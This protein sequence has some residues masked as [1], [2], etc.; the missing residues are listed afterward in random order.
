MGNCDKYSASEITV[1][2]CFCSPHPAGW[3]VANSELSMT[4]S[5]PLVSSVS[6][7]C[8]VIDVIIYNN[9]N[10]FIFT[11]DFFNYKNMILKVFVI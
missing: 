7:Q 5:Y 3:I 6:G 4:V 1:R 10:V 11:M 9:I 8:K 2:V